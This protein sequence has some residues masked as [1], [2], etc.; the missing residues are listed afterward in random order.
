MPCDFQFQFNNN[1]KLLLSNKII[2]T[3]TRL[4]FQV[5]HEVNQK[6]HHLLL[7]S[8]KTKTKLN[9]KT[10]K[11]RN[12]QTNQLFQSQKRLP[13]CRQYF[14]KNGK[15]LHFQKATDFVYFRPYDF[16]QIL[17]ACGPNTYQ[18]M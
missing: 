9:R 15:P 11:K 12:K 10:D 13:K 7:F 6:L 4:K 2:S 5:N 16:V 3:Y 1:A 17:P 18:I 14:V 8:Y